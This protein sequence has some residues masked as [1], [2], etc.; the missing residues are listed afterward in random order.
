VMV[1]AAELLGGPKS[2]CP[3]AAPERS[4]RYPVGGAVLKPKCDGRTGHVLEKVV[5]WRSVPPERNP[6]CRVPD[7]SN[8][9]RA[10]IGPFR[11]R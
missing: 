1:A 9:P 7:H 3:A 6:T 2:V 8:R 5:I 10:C 11:G 4:R